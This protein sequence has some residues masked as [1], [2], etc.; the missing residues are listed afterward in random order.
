MNGKATQEEIN[1]FIEKYNER[2]DWNIELRKYFDETFLSENPEDVGYIVDEWLNT[3]KITEENTDTT[4]ANIYE[5]DRKDGKKALELQA[6]D[7]D[8]CHWAYWW[9]GI[10]ET[11]D[12]YK[13]RTL[14]LLL[15]DILKEHNRL[16]DVINESI[17]QQN[18][19]CS[20]LMMAERARVSNMSKEDFIKEMKN[21]AVT[22]CRDGIRFGQFVFNHV[23]QVYGVA[24][25]AQFKHHVDCFYNDSNV[26]EFLSVCYDI[27]KN[28]QYAGQ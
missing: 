8:D 3:K 2:M 11:E 27:I 5:C 9:T 13:K 18:R 12:E 17:A 28:K 23:A 21:V 15:E 19:I 16:N 7:K 10:E 24:R 26:D 22:R 1:F 20:I 14:S 25:E 6:F 4:D